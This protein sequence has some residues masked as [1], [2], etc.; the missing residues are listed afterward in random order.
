MNYKKKLDELVDYFYWLAFE[1]TGFGAQ[2]RNLLTLHTLEFLAHEAD[3]PP[4]KFKRPE[5]WLA[6]IFDMTAQYHYLAPK[7]HNYEVLKKE[8][9]EGICKELQQTWVSFWENAKSRGIDKISDLVKDC[10]EEHLFNPKKCPYFPIRDKAKVETLTLATI[11]FHLPKLKKD[12]PKHSITH[13]QVKDKIRKEF[14][15]V[16]CRV[17]SRMQEE[18][19]SCWYELIAY[20]PPVGDQVVELILSYLCNEL[21][22]IGIGSKF[23]LFYALATDVP[24]GIG[25]SWVPPDCYV[26]DKKNLYRRESFEQERKGKDDAGKLRSL[27]IAR[28]GASKAFPEV[29]KMLDHY[30]NNNNEYPELHALKEWLVILGSQSGQDPFKHSL[31]EK[32]VLLVVNPDFTEDGRPLYATNRTT[33]SFLSK[34]KSIKDAVVLELSKKENKSKN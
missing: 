7:L 9:K 12:I 20:L 2:G 31:A 16:W 30:L 19:S 32:E 33:T 22:D 26:E 24:N 3:L 34:C 5:K 6:L 11:F 25:R 23:A 13:S 15:S 29:I 10:I 18:R 14:D 27:A 21:V 28:L 1:G 8:V 17:I 4:T